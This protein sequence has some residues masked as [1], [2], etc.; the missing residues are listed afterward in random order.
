MT[1]IPPYAKANGISNGTSLG[2]VAWWITAMRAKPN[3]SAYSAAPTMTRTQASPVVW[4]IKSPEVEPEPRIQYLGV[5]KGPDGGQ[6]GPCLRGPI[7]CA[8]MLPR[9]A[10]KNTLNSSR[11][12]L[13]AARMR[14]RPGFH[15]M[16]RTLLFARGSIYSSPGTIRNGRVPG[17]MCSMSESGL[18]T[19]WTLNRSRCSTGLRSRWE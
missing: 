4:R 2:C 19:Y 14:V 8:Q 10:C 7:H 17:P 18:S 16:F 3:T 5:G 1:P 15:S 11:T 12:R 6:T 9:M 13:S